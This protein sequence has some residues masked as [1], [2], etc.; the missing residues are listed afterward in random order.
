MMFCIQIFRKNVF[1][2]YVS[3]AYY[4]PQLYHPTLFNDGNNMLKILYP[5][6]SVLKYPFM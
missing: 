5:E 4:M 3:P 1:I 2:S 6:L